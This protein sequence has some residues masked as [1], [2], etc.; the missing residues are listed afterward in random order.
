MKLDPNLAQSI[1]DK[2]MESVPYNINMMNEKGYIIASGNKERINTLH[3]GAIDTIQ[4]GKTKPMVESFGKFGQ[5]GVNIPVEFNGETIGV[6]G[7]TGDPKKVTP[8]ASLLKISTELLIS[9]INNSK[10][11][12]QRKESLNHFLYQ[13]TSTDNILNNDE[14][15]LRA[16]TLKIDLTV[17]RYAVI[18]EAKS[19][20]K[21]QLNPTDFSFSKTSNQQLIITKNKSDLLR[22]LKF[23]QDNHLRIGI[24][25]RTTNLKEAVKQAQD[26]ITVST[27]LELTDIYYFKQISF[28]NH[29]LESNL[30]SN[31]TLDVFKSFLKTNSGLELLETLDSYFKHNGNVTDTSQALNIHRNTTNYR[32]NN[33]S[34]YFGLNLHDLTDTLQL[35]VNYLYFKKYQHEHK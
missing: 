18:I 28:L 17:K 34:E 20:A 3:I 14:L 24:S 31:R 19:L 27:E 5:P 8:L 25:N 23:C 6:I 32:L 35:Y 29:L 12:N 21:L 26:T 13:W 1:V 16:Q 9:Q 2:M 10:L 33:I 7:I 15:R 22:Y 11:E 4:S 30:H